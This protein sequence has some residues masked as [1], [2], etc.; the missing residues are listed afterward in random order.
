MNSRAYEQEAAL[1][2]IFEGSASWRALQLFRELPRGTVV[3]TLELAAMLHIKPSAV[4]QMIDT[5]V[6]LRVIRKVP[7]RPSWRRPGTNRASKC[8]GWTLGAGHE[9]TEILKRTS[10]LPPVVSPTRREKRVFEGIAAAPEY[11]FGASWPPGFVSQFFNT[12][13]TDSRGKYHLPMPAQERTSATSAAVRVLGEQ[14]TNSPRLD[15]HQQSTPPG[16]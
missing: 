12:P 13:L 8:I 11:R 9:D 2:Y 3:E 16:R 4:H 10:P 6:Q 1:G 15:T 7:N 14:R 5:A